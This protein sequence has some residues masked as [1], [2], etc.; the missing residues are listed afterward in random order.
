MPPL[1]AAIVYADGVYPETIFTRT[2][3]RLRDRGVDLAGTLQRAP[4][5]MVG[6]HPCDLL[7]EDLA[8]GEVTAIAEERG[9]MARGCRLD[10]AVL[11]CIAGAVIDSVRCRLPR[12]LVINK[13]GRV[14]AEGGGLFAAIGAAVERDIPV[15]AGVPARNLDSW[16]AFA[17]SLA[18]E[19]P[20]TQEAV[21]RWLAGRGLAIAAVAMEN[22]AMARPWTT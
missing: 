11:E 15:L 14:E 13:F 5:G 3:T 2:V 17:G 6:R 18:T 19:L 8:T 21:D 12:L 16:K 9:K 22:V 1:V 4:A 7:I 20:A 10:I